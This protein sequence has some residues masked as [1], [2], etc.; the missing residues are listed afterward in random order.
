MRIHSPYL[1]AATLISALAA[2]LLCPA[3]SPQLQSP[4]PGPQFEDVRQALAPLGAQRRGNAPKVVKGIYLS[5]W[6]ASM[7]SRVD[8]VIRLA[9]DGLINTVV[10]DVQAVMGPVAFDSKVPQT[11]E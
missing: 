4:F 9:Q 11:V 5:F 2:A 1:R 10:I 7:P 6:S 3:L 8:N